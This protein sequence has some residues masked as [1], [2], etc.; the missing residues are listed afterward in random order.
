MFKE[1][2]QS[3]RQILFEFYIKIARRIKFIDTKSTLMDA[4]GW[5]K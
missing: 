2:S 4:P 3:Q 5:G 1:I